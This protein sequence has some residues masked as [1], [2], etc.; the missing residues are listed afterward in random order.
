MLAFQKVFVP[1]YPKITTESPIWL[2]Q[3]KPSRSG[4]K[5]T[6]HVWACL[7]FRFIGAAPKA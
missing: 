1:L 3:E 6:L 5:G 4:Y 7:F 2:R